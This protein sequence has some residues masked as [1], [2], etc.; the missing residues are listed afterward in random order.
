VDGTTAGLGAVLHD[1]APN[2][3]EMLLDVVDE[4]MLDQ[5]GF[6]LTASTARSASV[7]LASVDAESFAAVWMS[8]KTVLSWLP[9]VSVT[10]AS[11]PASVWSRPHRPSGVLAIRSTSPVQ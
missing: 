6:L 1:V 11:L 9:A 5:R 3:A 7:S 8:F 4:E 10:A 2:L